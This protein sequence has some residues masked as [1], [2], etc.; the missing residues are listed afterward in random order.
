MTLTEPQAGKSST[1]GAALMCKKPKEK[2]R[3]RV[4]QSQ[5][6]EKILGEWNSDNFS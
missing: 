5:S 6:P 1:A 4:S 2:H 3:I